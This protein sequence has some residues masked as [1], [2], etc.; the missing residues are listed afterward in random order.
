MVDHV[1]WILEG[2]ALYQRPSLVFTAFI[3]PPFYLY[4]AAGLT[5]IFGVGFFSLRIISLFAT[6]GTSFFLYRLAFLETRNRWLSVIAP[7][8]FLA[9]YPLSGY[10][11]DLG[12]VD[13]LMLFFVMASVFVLRTAKTNKGI[14]IAGLLAVLA[15]FTKQLVWS[16]YLPV[17][18]A[19]FIQGRRKEALVFSLTTGILGGAIFLLINYFSHGWFWYYMV[20]VPAQH[21][22]EWEMLTYFWWR[23]L[24]FPTS[25]LCFFAGL[26]CYFRHQIE[27]SVWSFYVALLIGGIMMGWLG[28][29]HTGGYEN[30]L[31]P[32]YTILALVAV[33]SIHRLQQYLRE[34]NLPLGEVAVWVLLILQWSA[35]FYDPR[36]V[37][38]T[39]AMYDVQT[40]FQ[41][42]LASYPRPILVQSHGFWDGKT[43]TPINAHLMGVADIVRGSDDVM[44]EALI[45]EF[46]QQL[47]HHVYGT[48]V[49]DN[50]YRWERDLIEK[51]Y[52]LSTTLDLPEHWELSGAVSL[53]TRVYVP[54]P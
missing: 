3:Y 50:A 46:Q 35:L 23:D 53:P 48:I 30:V 8:L 11:M 13:N 39:R 12:R 52:V 40:Q 25:I 36:H 26:F 31:L 38:P 37:I 51:Y 1:R 27:R 14:I 54:R 29:L 34:R 15:L 28:R 16:L 22:W 41:A 5:K 6:A 19:L 20:D 33:L 9:T 18:I 21:L 17:V 7:G 44:R 49:L 32:T 2:H 24:L 47:I 42:A 10:W 43:T 45:Q 4:F